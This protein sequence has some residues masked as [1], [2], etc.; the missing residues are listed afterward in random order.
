MKWLMRNWS[1]S[2]IFL[3]IYM[4]IPLVL[5]VM[6]ENFVLFLIWI[7]IPCYFLHQF[8]EYILPGGFITFFNKKV[9]R[10][11]QADFPIGEKESF[12]INIPI[13]YIAF[14]LSAILATQFGVAFGI[15]IAYF[16]VINAASHVGMVFKH[17]YNPGFW[18]SLLINIPVGIFTIWYFASNQIIP[19]SAHIIG[20]LI[21]VAVQGTVMFYG[22]KVLKPKVT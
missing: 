6:K 11:K 22:F 7:Q 12:W 20:L 19:V 17:K 18:V 9:L 15:W 8:E 14:P 5:F 2:T 13:I 10:S 16:S 4:T 21:G 1:K 3:A